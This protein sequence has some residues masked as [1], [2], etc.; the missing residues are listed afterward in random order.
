MWIPTLNK[1]ELAALYCFVFLLIAARG[2]GQASLDG[3]LRRPPPPG[4]PRP[5]LSVPP[6]SVP[7]P[8]S[9]PNL[10]PVLVPRLF[11]ECQTATSSDLRERGTDP[12]TGT[13]TGTG[14]IVEGTPFLARGGVGGRG[15]R[16]GA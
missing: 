7:V 3:L 4:A 12:G 14:T 5:R 8:V 9:V 2:S 11:L 15:A 16:L 6:Q 1:G 10:S 13:G